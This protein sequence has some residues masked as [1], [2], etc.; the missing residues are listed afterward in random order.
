MNKELCASIFVIDP[1]AKK[2][3]LVEHEAFQKWIQIEGYL[4]D[5][6]I[7]YI[8]EETL[9]GCWFSREKLVK[10]NVFEDIKI[11]YDYIV[12]DLLY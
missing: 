9:S 7:P 5:N 11:T 10:I 4:E 12:R 6:K 2:I 8:D 1:D 3:F